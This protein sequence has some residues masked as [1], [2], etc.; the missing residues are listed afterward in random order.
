MILEE[1]C[2]IAL[3]KFFTKLEKDIHKIIDEY[4]ES[5][6]GLFHLN[7][8]SDLITLRKQQYYDILFKYCK[9][10][11][12]R[13]R[14][15]TKRIYDR[16]LEQMSIKSDIA[17]T[18]LSSLFN[19][20]PA[21]TYNLNNKIFVA[22]H[23]TMNRV[24]NLVMDNLS[25]SY[26]DGLG[27]EEAKN[28]LTV[29]YNGL[30]GWEARRIARTEI[31]SAQNDA[32]YD[33]CNELGCEY[34]QW[35]TAQD[36]RVRDGTKG[37]AD[38]RKLHGKIVRMGTAFSNGLLYPGDREGSISEWI[39]CRC[40]AI[41]YLMPLGMMAPPHLTE[42]TEDDLIPIP[43]FEMPTL[44]GALSGNYSIG[45]E[46]FNLPTLPIK[47]PHLASKIS[48]IERG[49][50]ANVKYMWLD[51][52][53]FKLLEYADGTKIEFNNDGAT[54]YLKSVVIDDVKYE[55]L[56]EESYE[57][58]KYQQYNIT[59]E[60]GIRKL[61]FL[62]NYSNKYATAQGMKLNRCLRLGEK[63]KGPLAK[64][65]KDFVELIKMSKIEKNVVSMRVQSS[66]HID[67]ALDKLYITEKAHF[68]SSTGTSIDDLTEVFVRFGHE[69]AGQHWE[70]ITVIPEKSETNALFLGNAL[71]TRRGQDWEYELNFAPNQSFKRLLVDEKNKII[72][73]TP[74]KEIPK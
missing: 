65:H 74:V 30:K 26:N 31:N 35:W 68:C 51:E 17:I 6:L 27:I 73:Q 49:K 18:T 53:D 11:Y 59:K 32:C 70:I 7:K 42:F 34:I 45:I 46:Q 25:Q 48:P 4:W 15:R 19:P 37:S 55:F 71:K 33:M 28:R 69:K 63:Y 44:E 52:S 24:D 8:I 23:H 47:N 13:S 66:L 2:S 39:N 64:E 38:H 10:Q 9:I 12:D 57:F 67:D 21:I 40:T 61:R 29:K 5:D 3:A 54:V 1:K 16:Q 36:E 60:M 43:K 14:K 20:D 58:F 62:Q 22:S 72:I 56:K 50:N 41:P